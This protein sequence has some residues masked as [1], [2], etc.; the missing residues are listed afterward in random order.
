VL[1]VLF[2]AYLA[3][4]LIMMQI[5]VMEQLI[6]L[7]QFHTQRYEHILIWVNS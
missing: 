3:S 6:A 5:P 2:L 4:S 1:S 7:I